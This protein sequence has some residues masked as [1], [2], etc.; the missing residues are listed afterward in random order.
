MEKGLLFF[1]LSVACLWLVLDEFYGGRKL[2][3]IAAAL[4]QGQTSMKWIDNGQ[5]N[6]S[7]EDAKKKIEDDPKLSK[8]EKDFLKKNIDHFYKDSQVN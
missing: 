8:E 3:S 7:K 6:K 1:T 4:S 5:A 2:S